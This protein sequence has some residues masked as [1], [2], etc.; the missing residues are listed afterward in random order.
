MKLIQKNDLKEINDI[1]D[2]LGILDNNILEFV[3]YNKQD[4]LKKVFLILLRNYIIK[5]Y[6]NNKILED[7]YSN[8]TESILLFIKSILNYT[9]PD[10]NTRNNIIRSLDYLEQ[11][12]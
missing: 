7:I 3:I 11:Y 6:N 12:L 1:D 9:N 2:G 10:I 5:Y 4:Y 8:N